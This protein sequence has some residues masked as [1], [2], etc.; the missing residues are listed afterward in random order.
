MEMV[1]GMG[2]SKA[3]DPPGSPSK[4]EPDFLAPP[5]QTSKKKTGLPDAFAFIFIGGAVVVT[6]MILS[7][8]YG[9]H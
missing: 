9:H 8:L 3:A 2:D 4:S 6:A 5:S 1:L 7:P